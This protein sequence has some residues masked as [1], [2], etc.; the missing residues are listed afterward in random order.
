VGSLE[1]RVLVSARRFGDLGVAG[2]D[3]TSPEPVVDVARPLTAA[4]LLESVA[5]VRPELPELD[6]AQ[7][8]VRRVAT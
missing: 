7:P 3:L 8:V 6:D 5:E 2:D 1:N 4:E